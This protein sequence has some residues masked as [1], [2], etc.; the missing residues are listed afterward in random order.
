MR[1]SYTDI[2]W[3]YAFMLLLRANIQRANLVISAV[4]L[5]ALIEFCP[6]KHLKLGASCRSSSFTI[7]R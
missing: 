1:D 6:L 5:P 4:Q 3:E 2:Q 7:H